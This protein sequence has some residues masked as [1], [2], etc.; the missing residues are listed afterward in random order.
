M[1]LWYNA[2]DVEGDGQVICW[3]LLLLSRGSTVEQR[4]RTVLTADRELEM[5]TGHLGWQCQPWWPTLAIV[6]VDGGPVSTSHTKY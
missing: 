4:T 1:K 2:W 3:L 5:E 6:V